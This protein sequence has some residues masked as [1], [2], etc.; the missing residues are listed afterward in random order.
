MYLLTYRLDLPS[1][2]TLFLISTLII[3]HSQ[4]IVLSLWFIVFQG[5]SQLSFHFSQA[6]SL[7]HRE[8]PFN[9]IF[10][11]FQVCTFSFLASAILQTSSIHSIL[12]PPFFP[13][14]QRFIFS[15]QSLSTQHLGLASW[16]LA[17]IPFWQDFA[18]YLL[19]LKG[20]WPIHLA[21]HEA[22]RV[23]YWTSTDF[24]SRKLLYLLALASLGQMLLFKS[25]NCS[26]IQSNAS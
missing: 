16:T 13:Y 21:S 14:L 10:M 26:M 20:V 15:H 11:R 9:L 2:L 12:T 24:A 1:I 18:L 5:L 4:L 25:C 19:H 23:F 7:F 22:Y 17:S 8:L 6:L 3:V